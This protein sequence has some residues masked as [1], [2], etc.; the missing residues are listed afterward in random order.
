MTVRQFQQTTAVIAAAG[1][2]SGIVI[3]ADY[4]LGGFSLPVFTG[5]GMT[6]LVSDDGTNFY[7]LKG[8][9]GSDVTALTVASSKSYQIPDDVFNHYSFKFKSGST[10]AAER[11]ISVFLKS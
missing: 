11:T 7:A 5:T 4:A 6:F 9:D 3:V 1:T 8:A 2:E 10:E